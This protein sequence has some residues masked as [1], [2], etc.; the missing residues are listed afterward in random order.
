VECTAQSTNVITLPASSWLSTPNQRETHTITLTRS[1]A[2]TN[3]LSWP[4][5][6]WMNANGTTNEPYRI[7]QGQAIEI[8]VVHFGGQTN[9]I[10]GYRTVTNANAFIY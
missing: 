9:W 3:Y 7:V 5:A 10:G 4:A 1:G 2:G 8:S 6:I